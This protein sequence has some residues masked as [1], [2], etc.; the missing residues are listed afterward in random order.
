MSCHL[1]DN[2]QC[3]NRPSIHIRRNLSLLLSL[4]IPEE[5]KH[6][7]ATIL[8]NVKYENLTRRGGM[9]KYTV[10]VLSW[11]CWLFP[12]L[13]TP[14]LLLPT[15][16]ICNTDWCWHWMYCQQLGGC[17]KSRS[18][19]QQWWPKHH[20]YSWKYREGK[21]WILMPKACWW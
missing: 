8:K 15:T 4:W 18:Q 5:V 16:K 19:V 14:I 1:W 2:F 17:R 7:E 21:S 12:C 20:Y 10:T 13:S 6:S 9:G 11:I 3:S